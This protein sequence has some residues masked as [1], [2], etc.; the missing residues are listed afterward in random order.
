[1]RWR[2]VIA[3]GWKI[4]AD[5]EQWIEFTDTFEAIKASMGGCAVRTNVQFPRFA[6]T[7]LLTAEEIMEAQ[8]HLGLV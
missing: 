5:C 1:M 2:E 4:L 6:E 3:E 8:E 7:S